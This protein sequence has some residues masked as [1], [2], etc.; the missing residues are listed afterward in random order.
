MSRCCS[1]DV[2]SFTF[3]LTLDTNV[4]VISITAIV[5][6]GLS[7]SVGIATDDRLDGLG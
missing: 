4:S 5:Y 6:S 1:V 7:S 3:L 2:D